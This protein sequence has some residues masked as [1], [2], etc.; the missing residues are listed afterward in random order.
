MAEPDAHATKV[1]EPET[2]PSPLETEESP[3]EC[4]VC[5]MAT[6]QDNPSEALESPCGCKGTGKWVHMSCAG[7][8]PTCDV[9]GQLFVFEN[10]HDAWSAI[11]WLEPIKLAVKVAYPM[12]AGGLLITFDYKAITYNYTNGF[13]VFGCLAT[14]MQRFRKLSDGTWTMYGANYGGSWGGRAILLETALLAM[15]LAWKLASGIVDGTLW[16]VKC[17]GY[18]TAW[19]YT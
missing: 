4:R 10:V 18:D 12:P 9:C 14:G 8:R 2:D 5:L 11:I 19:M 6:S 13:N 15:W 17:A 7:T 3:P 16:A 1:S